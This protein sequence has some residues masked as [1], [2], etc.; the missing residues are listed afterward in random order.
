MAGG[1][2]RSGVAETLPAADSELAV[3]VIIA[4]H[5]P[6]IGLAKRQIDS[7][8]AQAGVTLSGVA[9]LDG[10]ETA[11]DAALRD[12]IAAAGFDVVT[13]PEPLGVKGAFASGLERALAQA[14][15][16]QFFCYADQDDDWHV[17]KL[18]RLAAHAQR[19]GA[20]LVHCDARVVAE[21]GTLIANSLHRYESR[22]EPNDLLGTLLLNTVTG[23]T[24]L[25]PMMTARLALALMTQYNGS[26][27]H[28]HITA[29]AAASIGPQIYLDEAL[30][31]YVQHGGNKI[32][33]KLHQ[34]MARRRA[35]GSQHM[36]LYRKTSEAMYQERRAVAQ[37]LAQRGLLPRPLQL[38]FRT[39]HP[40]GVTSMMWAYTR[41]LF[42]LFAEL[43]FR[44]WMLA[45]RMMDAAL[46]GPRHLHNV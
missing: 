45:M 16:G 15:D 19:S 9:V 29:I 42:R 46:F 41:S 37:L 43:D 34:S 18:A 11:D 25:F 1:A 6:D 40:A 33:A 2:V 30:V 10:D 22:R 5:K 8:L 36:A 32:G 14:G 38:M 26:F 12:L 23:M 39:G 44:R 3:T 27:L 17:E 31:D 24:C 28:D 20:A 7:I 4:F 13:N 35:V 21:D